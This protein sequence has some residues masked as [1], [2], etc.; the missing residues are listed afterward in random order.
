MQDQK[1][2]TLCGRSFSGGGSDII[3]NIFANNGSH[4]CDYGLK[5]SHIPVII[6]DARPNIVDAPL[7]LISRIAQ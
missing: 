4:C 5:P 2:L 6:Q 1:S 3:N 7:M